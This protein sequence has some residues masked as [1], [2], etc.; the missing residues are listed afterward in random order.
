METRI[1]KLIS[2]SMQISKYMMHQ[3]NASFEERAATMLQ[4]HALSFLAKNP[5]AKLSEI[6]KYL[7]A[8]LSSTTQLVERMHKSNLIA[9]IGDTADR[10]VIH[11]VLT[12]EGKEKLKQIKEA[13]RTRIKKLFTNIDTHD[14]D[15][16]IR[17]QEKI[18]KSLGEEKK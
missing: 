17:I 4:A 16:L 6:A 5:N 2:L 11:H 1:D 13:K 3:P 10:R 15:E 8:S 7:T 12:D 14:M 9:R 18:V